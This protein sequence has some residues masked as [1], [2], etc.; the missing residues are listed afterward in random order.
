MFFKNMYALYLWNEIRRGI[1]F[2]LEYCVIAA[3]K[4]NTFLAL[5][6]LHFVQQYIQIMSEFI[7][8]GFSPLK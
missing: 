6:Q 7:S 8:E 3:I 5:K 1:N 2:Y 4:T